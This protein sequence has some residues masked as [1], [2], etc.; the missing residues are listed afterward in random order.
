M[1]NKNFQRTKIVATIGPSTANIKKLTLMYKAGM[2]IARLNGSHNNLE[3]HARTINLIKE[4]LPELPIL[5]DIPGK[6]IR[7]AILSYEP[8]F[9]IGDKLILTTERGY[10]GKKK[11]S[12]TSSTL[13]K[14]LKK[15]DLI[16][17]DDGT[18][19]FV[20]LKVLA[21]DIFVRAKTKG[22]LKSSKGINV[23][24]VDIE[25][26]LITKKDKEMISFSKKTK[27]D[28]IGISFVESAKHIK[29]IRSL[30][31]KKTPKIVAKVEN[32]NGLINI[33]EIIKETD[34][35]MI[36]R[37]DLSTETNIESLAI[38]QKFIINKSI[39]HAKPVIVATEML[40][41]MITNSYPTK[42]EVLDISNSIL[43]GA[44]ATMLS[45]ETAVG[46]YP[47]EAIRVMSN[48]SNSSIKFKDNL[49]PDI[50]HKNDSDVYGTAKA[51]RNICLSLPVTKII[52]ITVSG[53]AAR[54]ISSQLLFQPIIAITNNKETARLTN[55]FAGTKGVY[56]DTE[57]YKNS[58]DHIPKCLFHLWK[59]KYIQPKDMLLITALAYPGSGRRMNLIQT[60]YV[61]D[62]IKTFSWK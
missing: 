57:F 18:L 13:H 42:A 38:N 12:L 49:Q 33:D 34:V 59:Q 29:K 45:G 48:I 17:A 52:A 46:K 10:D 51:I 43:D 40:D 14:Y 47:V 24:H 53:F 26:D 44:T 21:Q 55:L 41:N 6:K 7:T 61:K 23:P 37:G 36:D 2:S 11:V 4:T 28:Y 22:V 20:V 39:Q 15:N 19:R 58:L 8:E 16:F 30:I 31:N 60:L 50:N 1:K 3:W 9:D 5:L 35:I 32:K 56:F 54:I 25:G 62:L 27:I